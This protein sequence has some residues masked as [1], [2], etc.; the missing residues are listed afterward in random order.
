MPGMHNVFISYSGQDSKWIGLL[1]SRLRDQGI[2][3]WQY[4]AISPGSIIDDEVRRKLEKSHCVLV[5]WSPASVRSEWVKSEAIWAESNS[6]LI[7][8]STHTDLD[9]P[10]Q[11]LSRRTDS[12][13]DW[14]GDVRDPLFLTLVETIESHSSHAPVERKTATSTLSRKV[15]QDRFNAS[16]KTQRIALIMALLAVP[17]LSVVWFGVSSKEAASTLNFNFALYSGARGGEH[18]RVMSGGELRSGGLYWITAESHQSAHLYVF[19]RDSVG[20]IDKLFPRSGTSSKLRS[21]AHVSIP[22]SGSFQL[23]DQTGQEAIFFIGRHTSDA[24]LD[25]MPERILPN[26]SNPC[27]VWFDT[28][29]AEMKSVSPTEQSL[30]KGLNAVI[31]TEI[32][33]GCDN[34]VYYI[35]FNHT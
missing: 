2:S 18:Q 3:I 16:A 15:Q 29:W 13:A 1:E 7:T 12:F 19:Q 24:C 4:T 6:N 20:Q 32:E 30:G 17:S 21:G 25:T 22:S 34:C 35:E 31:N 8:I 33:L 27:A 11:F 28:Q 10:I 26:Q 14:N 9:I 23:N 5:V